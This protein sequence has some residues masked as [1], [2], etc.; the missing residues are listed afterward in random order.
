MHKQGFVLEMSIGK[1]LFRLL[2]HL[3][4]LPKT[5]SGTDC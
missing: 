3:A 4:C 2:W 5:S 1:I